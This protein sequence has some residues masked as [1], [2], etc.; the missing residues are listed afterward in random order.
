M[1]Y[2]I[3][4][5]KGGCG[6]TTV[7]TNLTILLANAGRDVLLVDADDQET[8]TDFTAWRNQTT[9]GQAGYTAIQLTGDAVRTEILKLVDKYDDIVVDT[10]GRDTTSQR[11]ALTV[12]DMYLVPFI[13]R[14]FDMW[15]LEKV[16]RLVEEI[17]SVNVKLQAFAFLNRADPRG[18]DNQEAAD[19]LKENDALTFLDAPLG[20]RKAFSNAATQGLAVTEL[21]PANPKAIEEVTTLFQRCYNVKS[22]TANNVR[23]A[24]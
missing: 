15:T 24:G 16:V 12:A 20:D 17:R 10:G 14:S 7:A 8:A 23:K 1:I 19:Y 5:I 2:T 9:E 3:G 13:P 4:G 6:K 22:N 18:V 21:K 11:A